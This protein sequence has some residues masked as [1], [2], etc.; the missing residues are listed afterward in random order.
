[1]Q[2]GRLKAWIGRGLAAAVCLAASDEA[3]AQGCAMCA[4]SASAVKAA[5]LAALRNGIFILLIPPIIAFVVI[6]IVAFRSRERGDEPK[7][8]EGALD[9]EFNEWLARLDP[10]ER[11]TPELEDSREPHRDPV[12]RT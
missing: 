7:P 2:F 8:K 10:P 12:S 5:A 11:F 9:R 4:S 3:F 1:M 6:F